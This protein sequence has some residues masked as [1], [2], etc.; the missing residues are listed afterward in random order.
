MGA[1]VGSEGMLVVDTTSYNVFARR[2]LDYVE[3]AEHRSD[4]RF[5]VVSHR[6]FDHFGGADAITAPVIGH[7]L[8][9]A[10]MLG[11]TPEWL[12]RNLATWTQQNLIIPELVRDPLIVVP[13]ITF[14]VSLELHLGD[15]EVQVLHVGGHTTDQS[16]V[17]VPARRVLF[18][19]D[20]IFH[21]RKPFVGHGD[22]VAWIGALERMRELPVDTVVPGHGPVDGPRLI[23]EQRRELEDMLEKSLAMWP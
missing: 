5:L 6:H 9:R 16:V 2:F 14:D 23:D 18:G 4:W 12:S 10:A 17:Y 19:S 20:N 21:Q 1:I 3:T 11:Y 8:T 7:R 13:Q 15:L 22:L